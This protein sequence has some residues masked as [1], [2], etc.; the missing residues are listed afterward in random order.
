[1]RVLSTVEQKQVG[2]GDITVNA[3][4]SYSINSQVINT[5]LYPSGEMWRS[6]AT[7]DGW[8]IMEFT[9]GSFEIVAG[10]GDRREYN[11]TG[12]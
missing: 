5:T 9:D 3:D 7:I 11:D 1:M 4:G 6:T 2:G 8:S 10:N 12:E